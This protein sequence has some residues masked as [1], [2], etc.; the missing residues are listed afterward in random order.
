MQKKLSADSEAV[1]TVVL[2]TALL[3]LFPGASRVVE[4][5]AGTVGDVIES[6]N[7]RWPGMWDRLVD[8]TPAIRCHLNIF[9]EGQ[10]AELGTQIAPG[11]RVTILTSMS[12][13]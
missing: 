8:S 6:L 1:V 12:G 9:V 3:R 11:T 5:E 7:T 4:L 13:G 10:R 2:P